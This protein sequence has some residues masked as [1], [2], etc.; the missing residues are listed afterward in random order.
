MDAFPNAKVRVIQRPAKKLIC[1]NAVRTVFDLCNFDEDETSEG[2]QCL[3]NYA[4]KLKDSGQFS[5]E[6]DHDTPWSHGSD[7]LQT[8]GLSLK[9]EKEDKKTVAVSTKNKPNFRSTGWMGA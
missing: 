1:I 4:Y 7:A 9:P 2:W 5:K 6:P 3:T 8:F